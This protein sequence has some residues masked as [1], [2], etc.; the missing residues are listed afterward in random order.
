MQSLIFSVE[1]SQPE[2]YQVIFN[3]K[4]NKLT[5]TCSCA[6]GESGQFCKHRSNLFNGD[7]TSLLS[8]N[9]DQLPLALDWLNKSQIPTE[10]KALDGLIQKSEQLK[11]DITNKKKQIA[12]LCNGL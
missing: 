10:I 11:K 9:K 4:D 6:A 7:V 8:N 1:G 5:V 12:R 2:P 3:N